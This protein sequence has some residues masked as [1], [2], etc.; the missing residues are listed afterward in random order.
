[1]L[2]LTVDLASKE[3]VPACAGAAAGWPC[4]EVGPAVGGDPGGEVGPAAT[5]SAAL[6]SVGSSWP[7]ITAAEPSLGS[8][9]KNS[10]SLG[11]LEQV[12]KMSKRSGP[13]CGGAAAGWPCVEGGWPC[14]EV[15]GAAAGWPCV[16]AG[17]GT[18]RWFSVSAICLVVDNEA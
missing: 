11:A 17:I 8:A 4:G 6:D 7:P 12:E 14:G 16:E 18:P 15:A 13:P 10:C 2:R 3:S 9:S 5:S 1:M